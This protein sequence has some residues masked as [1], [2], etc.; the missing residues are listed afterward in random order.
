VEAATT[1]AHGGL[2]AAVACAGVGAA[3]A[4]RAVVTRGIAILQLAAALAGCGVQLRVLGGFLGFAAA[5]LPAS[6]HSDR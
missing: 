5:A 6:S 2:T 1:I 4:G 3:A